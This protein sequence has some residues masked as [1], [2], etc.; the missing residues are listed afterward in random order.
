MGPIRSALIA[1]ACLT[2]ILAAQDI[3]LP[4]G[5]AKKIVQHSCAECHGLDK[6]VSASHTPEQW[7][8]TVERM[9]KK[10]AS[11]TPE[12]IETVVDYLTVYFAAEKINVN[13]AGSQDLQ[14]GLQLTSAEADAIVAFRKAN[15][16]YKDVEALRKVQGLDF[17][18][19]EAKKDQLAF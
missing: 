17:K 10:G 14:S 1:A 6:V 13:T 9:A 8:T 7:R 18:K 12:D 4:E 3:E 15:G 5:K 19:L 11:L 16:P 2:C